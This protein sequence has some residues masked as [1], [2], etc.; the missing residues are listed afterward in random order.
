MYLQ[1]TAVGREDYG[2]H[3]YME[4][5]QFVYCLLSR[6]RQLSELP[7]LHN[8]EAYMDVTKI[9]KLKKIDT[10]DFL[11]SHNFGEELQRRKT[12]EMH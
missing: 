2:F 9:E 8:W 6:T 3:C 1:E 11:L 10:A 7:A 5:C 12:G 4:I